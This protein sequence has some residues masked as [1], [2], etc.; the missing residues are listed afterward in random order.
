[1]SRR[2]WTNIQLPYLAHNLA[3]IKLKLAANTQVML[4]IKADAYGHGAFEIAQKAIACGIE[5][6]GVANCAEGMLL[7][8][9]GI[10]MPLLILSPSLI[11]EIDDII[12]W[13]L[14][15][16]ISDNDFAKALQAQANMPLA[17]HVNVDSG[18]GRSGFSACVAGELLN[19]WPYDKLNIEGVFSHF[20]TAETDATYSQKQISI[21]EQVIA[22]LH[23]VPPLVHMA[24]SAGML[25]GYSLTCNMVRV[26]IAAYGVYTHA[27]QKELVD[28][29]PV[30]SFMTK[31]AQI[32][33]ARAGE[34]I[35][36]GRSYVVENDTRYAILPVGYADGYDYLLSNKA[37]VLINKQLCPV[38]G[39][40]SMDMTVVEIGDIKAQIGD[41]V[42]LFGTLHDDL[43]VEHLA[44]LYNGNCYELL[45]QTGRR[46]QPYYY[47]TNK[48]VQIKAMLRRDFAPFDMDNG[49]LSRH[50]TSAIQARVESA[51]IAQML[52]RDV[53]NK[54]FVDKDNDIAWRRD[55]YHTVEFFNDVQHPDYYRVKTILRYKKIIKKDCFLIACASDGEQ[56]EK[57][58]QQAEVEYRWLL[59]K[60]FPLEQ[61]FFVVTNVMV[62]DMRLDMETVTK[63]NSLETHCQAACLQE[64]LGQEAEYLIE[65]ETYYPKAATQLSIFIN[66]IT[67]GVFIKFIYPND[68]RELT[69][70]PILSG[71]T[72]FPQTSIARGEATVFTQ[73]SEWIF[74]SSGV[75]FAYKNAL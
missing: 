9:Q 72:R 62:N 52:S 8:Y 32:K 16:S 39:R 43:R 71:K 61:T 66:D 1:M 5:F 38:L 3:Q 57:Y 2:S 29:R 33:E 27:L 48:E 50:I 34:S 20:S 67:K 13:Q 47:D 22:S 60:N 45:C 54:F 28:L 30:M 42:C 51:E 24:N 7:R 25:A 65:T 75:V 11:S 70:V 64:I 31:I 68:I 6:F 15:P 19:N 36:Y 49:E 55:F 21:F 46:A 63:D 26:G 59:D 10:K 74:P 12:K 53:L 18:M 14:I 56:L 41:E 4:I 35:G 23:T 44:D 37:E 69:V 58:L 17:V 40:I 73:G